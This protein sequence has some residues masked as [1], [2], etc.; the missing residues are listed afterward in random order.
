MAIDL[1]LTITPDLLDLAARMAGSLH[2][3]EGGSYQDSEN[4]VFYALTELWR[5]DR[6]KPGCVSDPR[7]WMWKAATRELRRNLKK[8][9][10]EVTVDLLPDR[11][12]D[13]ETRPQAVQLRK[14]STR[15]AQE[16]VARLAEGER[17][18]VA[19]YHFA[20]LSSGEIA[21]TLQISEEAIRARLSRGH[22]RLKKI[23]KE[24]GGTTP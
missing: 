3:S 7:A 24:E 4:A 1:S 2:A 14:E 8:A 10:A 15:R 17:A 21:E 19:L 18:A 20:E 16:L 11:D 22:R 9:R 23:L 12:D 13:A 5:R 6:K